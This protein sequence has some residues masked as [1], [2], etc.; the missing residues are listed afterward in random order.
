M[1][2]LIFCRKKKSVMEMLACK[3]LLFQ[4]EESSES[5]VEEELKAIFEEKGRE[6]EER[7]R[8]EEEERLEMERWMEDRR[9]EERIIL[10]GN[11]E[12]MK[13]KKIKNG[14]ETSQ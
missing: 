6:E 10:E 3:I 1:T 7:L 5:R 4:Q 11:T 2:G 13:P 12:E 8:I 14:F 9:D